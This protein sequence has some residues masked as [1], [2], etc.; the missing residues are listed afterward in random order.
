MVNSGSAPA[1]DLDL[2]APPPSGW[3]VEFEP[4][5]IPSL[6][7]GASGPVAVKIT[8]SERAVAGDYMVGLRATGDP[9]AEDVQFRTTV[10]T[11]TVWGIAG[12]GVIGVAVIVLAGTVMRYGRR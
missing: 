5:Q 9:I 11:S 3:K 2:S 1:T 7:P 8:P 10:K 12:L 6:G 4:K